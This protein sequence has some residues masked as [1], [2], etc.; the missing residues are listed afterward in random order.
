V[1][2]VIPAILTAAGTVLVVS[3]T[4]ILILKALIDAGIIP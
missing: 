1:I 4:G 3:G 2:F